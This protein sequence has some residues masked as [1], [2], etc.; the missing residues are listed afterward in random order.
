MPTRAVEMNVIQNQASSLGHPG[1]FHSMV[2]PRIGRSGFPWPLPIRSR[3]GK[4]CRR[5]ARTQMGHLRV[6]GRLFNPGERIVLMIPVSALQPFFDSLLAPI[7]ISSS[8]VAHS[9]CPP[10]AYDLIVANH[11]IRFLRGPFEPFQIIRTNK[12]RLFE[13]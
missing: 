3:N 11:I 8:T 9:K 1:Q 4:H 5:I 7:H 12:S 2:F 13:A 6:S 10:G